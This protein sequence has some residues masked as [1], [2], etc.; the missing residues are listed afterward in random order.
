MT[1]TLY[2][3]KIYA[4]RNPTGIV[5]FACP[6]GV[7]RWTVAWAIKQI[8]RAGFSVVVYDFD[9]KILSGS[10]LSLLPKTISQVSSDIHDLI[11]RY[12]ADEQSNFGIFGTSLGSFV[13]FS[14]VANNAEISWGVFNTAGNAAKG[15]WNIPQARKSLVRHGHSLP[16]LLNAWSKVQDPLFKTNATK[17]D[18]LFIGSNRDEVVPLNELEQYTNGMKS[19]GINIE[20]REYSKGRHITTAIC[21]LRN[22]GRLVAELNTRNLEH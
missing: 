18:F 2:T 10:D 20:I 8:Q 1:T 17:R 5:F 9:N 22:A 6:F 11:E 15:A 3:R 7:K 14:A 19:A 21:G 12:A 16:T 13:L 4:H